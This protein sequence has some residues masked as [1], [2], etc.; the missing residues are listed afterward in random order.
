MSD[1]ELM[2]RF[3]EFESEDCFSATESQRI[4][5]LL[6]N[7]SLVDIPENSL[8]LTA[9]YLVQVLNM[10]EADIDIKKNLERLLKSIQ[11]R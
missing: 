6:S 8:R 9:D 4:N 2:R 3:F 1:I 5:T 7:M 11:E 10:G